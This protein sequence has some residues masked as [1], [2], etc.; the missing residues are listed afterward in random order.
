MGVRLMTIIDAP[1]TRN[2]QRALDAPAVSG[3]FEDPLREHRLRY[4]DGQIW[5]DHVTHYGPSPCQHC[6]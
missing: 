1:Q 2:V 6:A 4:H 5:T 3:W